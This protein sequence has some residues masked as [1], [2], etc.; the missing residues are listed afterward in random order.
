MLRE[1]NTRKSAGVANC[2]QHAKTEPERRTH[3]DS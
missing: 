1:A 2:N 3:G